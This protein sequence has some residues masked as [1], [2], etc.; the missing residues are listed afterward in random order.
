MPGPDYEKTHSFEPTRL[1]ASHVWRCRAETQLSET[2]QTA[3]ASQDAA[4]AAVRGAWL[5]FCL[6]GSI[7]K[8]RKFCGSPVPV[9][10]TKYIR[11]TYS[12]QSIK[13]VLGLF[14]VLCVLSRL[15]GYVDIDAG[16]VFFSTMYHRNDDLFLRRV[17]VV[18]SD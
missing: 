9:S 6:A 17:L 1:L 16:F 15:S 18:S 7:H 11:M 8:M 5:F 13:T 4:S 3:H 10:T 14:F 2:D 12:G